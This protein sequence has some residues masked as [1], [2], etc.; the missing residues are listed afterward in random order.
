MLSRHFLRS[1]V[2]QAIYATQCNESSNA[3]E[4][5][6]TFD[7]HMQRLNELGVLQIGALP[8][9]VDTCAV[10]LDEGK[11]KF[12]PTKEEL[13]PNTKL[14]DNEFIRRITDNYE[15][16]KHFDNWGGCWQV[17]DDAMRD[18]FLQLRK[19]D[20]YAE[21]LEDER[22]TFE[23]DKAF[24]IQLFRFLMTREVLATVLEE[25]SLL[26]EDDFYQIAQYNYMMLK[27]IEEASFNE[28]TPWPLMY[29]A[30]VV[31]DEEAMSFA[32]NLLSFT[33]INQTEYEQ[34]I[35]QHLQGWEFERVAHMDVLLVEMAISELIN[36]PSIPEKVTVDEYIELSKEFSSE[37]SKLFI[38][39]II[40]KIIIELRSKGRIVKSGRGLL[41]DPQSL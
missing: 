23:T 3:N 32:R 15:L 37:R 6:R 1:K 28:A 4:A 5:L 34:I 40:D 7:Y 20:F 12:M 17:H 14:L 33:I 25:R 38:N 22:H 36:C 8:A 29:D 27:T 11:H 18:A 2:L 35:K 24:A 21:Y 13:N 16:K 26:W 30:R 10:V 31:K 39:G 19:Q 9:I 41:S